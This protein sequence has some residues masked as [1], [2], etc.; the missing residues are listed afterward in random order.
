MSD[1]SVTINTV[2]QLAQTSKTTVSFY[3]N[4]KFDKM[5]DETR[6][7]IEKA[8][9][10]TNYHPSLA[11]R[12]LNQKRTKMVGVILGDIT[13]SFSNQ[14]VKGIE[15]VALQQDYQI[16]LGNSGYDSRVEQ[17]YS[18]RMLNMGVDGLI[19]QPTLQFSDVAEKLETLG[20]PIVFLDSSAKRV[21]NSRVGADSRTATREATK[22]CLAKGYEDFIML[23]ADPAKLS[24]RKDRTSSFTAT[25]KKAGKTCV[26]LLL[27][28]DTAPAEIADFVTEHLRLNRRTLIFVP[29]CW[30]LPT[31][32][33]A[34]GNVRNLIPDTVGVIGFDN[35]EWTRF[36][37]PSITTI[38]QP[39]YEEGRTAMR[40]L[41]DILSGAQKRPAAEMLACTISWC[42]ST[43]LHI[44]GAGQN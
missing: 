37:V 9:E 41:Y 34:L 17:K 3:L 21:K 10:A 35:T 19:V 42:E 36:S 27:Q 33:L 5:S 18:E 29:T 4:G 6:H 16:V 32:Y 11:A 22:A 44:P 26:T 30:A 12:S 40:I 14:I 2:A 31:V 1:R 25:L 24:V 13:N 38:V 15:N 43:N 8:I 23:T 28:A 39:A 20:V 7:R